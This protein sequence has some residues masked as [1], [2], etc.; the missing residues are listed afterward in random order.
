M[1]HVDRRNG[2]TVRRHTLASLCLG[3]KTGQKFLLMRTIR[4][5]KLV[6][7][8]FML[9]ASRFML[10]RSS[11][12]PPLRLASPYPPCTKDTTQAATYKFTQFRR[13]ALADPIGG[14]EKIAGSIRL[15][16][17]A[18]TGRKPILAMTSCIRSTPGAISVN[19]NLPLS[20]IKTALS[21]T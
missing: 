19:V 20:N 3:E 10:P 6:L 9:Y 2:D 5:E 17:S 21:V 12:S 16:F 4:C 1:G 11:M 14:V 8:R 15:R 18:I 7:T 13:T